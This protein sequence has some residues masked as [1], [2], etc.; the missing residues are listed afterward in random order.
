MAFLE[1]VRQ[2]RSVRKYRPDPVPAAQLDYVLEA[3]RLAPSW[4]NGQCCSYLVVTDERVRHELAKAGND[5]IAQAPVIIVVCADPKQS[6]M[7]GDQ[8]YYML[9]AGISMEHLVL[10]AAEQGLGTCW[11][12]WFDEEIAR[13]ALGVPE[14]IRIVASTPLGFPDEETEARP[15]KSLPELVHR[16]RWG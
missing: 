2:R 9:D 16:D 3:A 13:Q 1:L 5:W 15:R 4:G 6:G 10:A 7:K 14:G 11:I 12:G 8:P